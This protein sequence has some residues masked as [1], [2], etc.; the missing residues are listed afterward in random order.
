MEYIVKRMKTCSA[1]GLDGV[2]MRAIR[3]LVKAY[4]TFLAKFCN[5]VFEGGDVPESGGRGGYLYYQKREWII[6]V[7]KIG[8]QLQLHLYH[9]EP[10]CRYLRIVFRSIWNPRI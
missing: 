6:I 5:H 2:S 4:Y 7:W 8:G 10:L 9:I 1:M 3:F